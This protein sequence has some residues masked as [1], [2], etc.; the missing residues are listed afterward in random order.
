V[1]WY[2]SRMSEAVTA[3]KQG[4]FLHNAECGARAPP[5]AGRPVRA[6]GAMVAPRESC[7][8]VHSWAAAEAAA[9]AVREL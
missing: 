4:R 7:T 1:R 6:T 2:E 9:F 5:A 3:R 8:S